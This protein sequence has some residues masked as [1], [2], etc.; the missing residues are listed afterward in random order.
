MVVGQQGQDVMQSARK[1]IRI[2]RLLLSLLAILLIIALAITGVS[3]YVGY[4]LIHPQRNLHYLN[5]TPADYHIP[6]QNVTFYSRRDHI[7]LD[8]WEMRTVTTQHR[9]VIISHGYASNR[10]FWGEDT[11]RLYQFFLQQGYNIATFDYSDSGKSGG[12][13]STVGI[14]EQADLLGALD[15]LEQ[16]DPQASIGLYGISQG[17]AV[18]LLIAGQ[19][20]HVSFVIADS[21]FADLHSFLSTNLPTWSHLPT[22]PFTPVILLL[23]QAMLQQNIDNTSPLKALA[24]FHGPILLTHSRADQSIPVANSR[25]IYAAYKG[26]KD[27]TYKEFA[28]SSHAH[29][30]VTEHA[31]Y[32]AALKAFL[33]HVNSVAMP[34]KT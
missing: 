19:H 12:N 28:I 33:A 14:W 1:G 10:L 25:Q 18:S 20:T 21:S 22:I 27:I 7:K 34:L 8:G 30:F 11:F 31:T 23:V 15:D 5:L 6:Y 3:Y 9:W 17:A 24:S 29:E 2:K 32:V 26:K 4:S 13:T 16:Q